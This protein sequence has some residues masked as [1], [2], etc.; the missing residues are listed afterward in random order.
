MPAGGV[1][2]SCERLVRL[3]VGC[4]GEGEGFGVGGVS[5]PDVVGEGSTGGVDEEAWDW[6]AFIDA[7]EEGEGWGE[8]EGAQWGDCELARFAESVCGESGQL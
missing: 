6:R 5:S 7:G 4:D 3:F 1:E 8:N 2:G